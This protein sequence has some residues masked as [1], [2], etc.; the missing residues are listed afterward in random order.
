MLHSGGGGAPPTPTP[1]AL[2]TCT[3][4][5]PLHAMLAILVAEYAPA[6]ASGSNPICTQSALLSLELTFPL[7]K[8]SPECEKTMLKWSDANECFSWAPS[9]SLL[10]WISHTPDSTGSHVTTPLPNTAT[11]TGSI[12]DSTG[13]LC[14]CQQLATAGDP[15]PPS[16]QPTTPPTHHQAG[17]RGGGAGCSCSRQRSEVNLSTLLCHQLRA[18][19][20]CS[21]PPPKYERIVIS[22]SNTRKSLDTDDI[23]EI[24]TA[25]RVI[26]YHGIYSMLQRHCPPA[27]HVH[28][29]THT[30]TLAR[31]QLV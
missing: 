24:T 7:A 2:H 8:I 6:P 10:T 23:A 25:K 12:S 14:M 17:R 18:T 11:C 27:M 15:P 31:R 21:A 1:P 28:T 20:Q 3:S 22:S 4:A 16:R 30:H 5:H 19:E 9:S 29:H 26:Q 13:T